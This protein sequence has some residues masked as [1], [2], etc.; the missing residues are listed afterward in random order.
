AKIL[1]V[2]EKNIYDK[3]ALGEFFHVGYDILNKLDIFDCFYNTVNVNFE[4]QREKKHLHD[5]FKNY[6]NFNC[7]VSSENNEC[8]KY[9][10]Y[11][12]F[13]NIL[14][15][16]YLDKSCDCFKYEGCKERYPY[17]FKCDEKY[18]PFKLFHKLQCKKFEQLSNDFK[19]LNW[20]NKKS[21]IIP[22]VVHD[23]I[24]SDPFNTFALGS[25]GF[26][27]VFLILFILYKFTP[28]RSYSNNRDARN[29]ES[30]FE[31]FEQQFL[32]DE[33]QFKHGNT[34]NRRM[35]IAYHQA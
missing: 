13:I 20:G 7:K 2:D 26:L 33:V 21:F 4:E 15:R 17:Y 14:Y 23:K 9:C 22:E 8:Q 11:V 16:K 27:G 28:M 30:Y 12:L 19:T 5:Y 32:E 35:H 34:Q 29:K 24:M 25:L 1:N 18:N 31:N 10:E 6:G 3:D